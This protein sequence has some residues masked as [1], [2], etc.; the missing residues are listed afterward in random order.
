MRTESFIIQTSGT[1][2]LECAQRA[3]YRE[4]TGTI[5]LQCVERTLLQTLLVP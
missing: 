4:T 2:V 3:L 5:G 1:I